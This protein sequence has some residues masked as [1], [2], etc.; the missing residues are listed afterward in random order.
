MGPGL[1]WGRSE[2][3]YLSGLSLAKYIVVTCDSTSMISEAALTGKPIYVAN[4]LP[5]K[6]LTV[7]TKYGEVNVKEVTTP[8]GSKRHKIEYESLR[9]IKEKHDVG[10]S[11]LQGELYDVI[12]IEHNSHR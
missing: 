7:S 2:K 12:R 8:S 9:R 11:Q 5:R 3:A 1:G 4:I 6:N 10:I